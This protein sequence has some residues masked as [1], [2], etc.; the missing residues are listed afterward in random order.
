MSCSASAGKWFIHYLCISAEQPLVITMT[1][2]IFLWKPKI[3]L[4]QNSLSRLFHL[5]FLPSHLLFYQKMILTKALPKCHRCYK[6]QINPSQILS[7]IACLL[8][9]VSNPHFGSFGVLCTVYRCHCLGSLKDYWVQLTLCDPKKGLLEQ[10]FPPLQSL[11]SLEPC[12][13]QLWGPGS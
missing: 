10:P 9:R 8:H 4:F 6:K 1:F 7:K 2:D 11:D 12:R 3:I 5:L 13:A